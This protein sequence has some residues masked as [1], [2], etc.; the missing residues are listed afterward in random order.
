LK[1]AKRNKPFILLLSISVFCFACSS[2]KI[3]EEVLVKVYVENIIVNE[4]YSAN[5]DSIKIH[6]DLV[7]T[8]YHITEKEFESELQ[9]YSD[10][11]SGWEDFFKKANDY[12]NDLKKQNKIN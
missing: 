7:F 5:P 10:D 11:K 8:K 12:L 9:K 1:P 4:T 2:K 3:P 6:K